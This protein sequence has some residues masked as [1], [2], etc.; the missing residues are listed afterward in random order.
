MVQIS[1]T[2]FTLIILLIGAGSCFAAESDLPAASIVA[3]KVKKVYSDKCCF[4]A[5]FDQVTVNVS[6]DI[7]DRFRGTIYVKKPGRI[8]LDVTWPEKQNLV[9]KGKSYVVYFPEDGSGAR[10]EV[11]PE[12]N[13]EHFFGFFANIGDMDRNFSVAYPD[14]V[15][16]GSKDL[17]MLQLTDKK[18]PQSTYRLM[19]GIDKEKYTIKRAIVYDALGNY[20]RF[21]LTD[22]S[23]LDAIPKERFEIDYASPQRTNPTEEPLPKPSESR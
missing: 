13:V 19:L 10:G 20:N 1:R 6:M 5:Q 7:R 2:V 21:D 23:F 22:V 17:I 3:D 12:M 15:G 18:N 11:P 16:T 14:T 8:A 4:K 9:I